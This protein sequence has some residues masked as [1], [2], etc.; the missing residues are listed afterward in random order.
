M[1]VRVGTISQIA[2]HCD[3][4]V[5]D[6]DNFDANNFDVIHIDERPHAVVFTIEANDGE[7]HRHDSRG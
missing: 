1:K 5:H 6:T 3:I 2:I 7:E 4:L